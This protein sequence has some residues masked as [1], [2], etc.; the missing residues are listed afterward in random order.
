MKYKFLKEISKP[1]YSLFGSAYDVYL[2]AKELKE[3]TLEE[4][5][6]TIKKQYNEEISKNIIQDLDDGLQV[7]VKKGLVSTL[8]KVAMAEYKRTLEESQ[9]EYDA[10]LKIV[11]EVAY[12]PLRKIAKEHGLSLKQSRRPTK[13]VTDTKSW[14][15]LIK[16]EGSDDNC[17]VGFDVHFGHYGKPGTVRIWYL[18]TNLKTMEEKPQVYEDVP[19]SKLP[20]LLE[21]SIKDFAKRLAANEGIDAKEAKK[22]HLGLKY[23]WD[24]DR[25]GDDYTITTDF[26]SDGEV[27]ATIYTWGEAHFEIDGEEEEFEYGKSNNDTQ[28]KM[29]A[30]YDK[31]LKE[32]GG[33]LP[34]PHHLVITIQSGFIENTPDLE[35]IK[36][37]KELTDIL[38]NLASEKAWGSGLAEGISDGDA[39]AQWVLDEAASRI[40]TEIEKAKKNK[41]K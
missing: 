10:A 20:K 18:V 9:A 13:S 31:E 17:R 30:Y 6:E 38:F 11:D 14:V 8:K 19:L 29:E 34:S 27:Y 15:T 36:S 7:L 41:K 3:F 33:S 28:K 25:D 40:W 21:S 39:K 22:T 5:K 2:A 26:G 16:V 32:R 35:K 23:D 37:K 12:D 1:H 24:W 4:L